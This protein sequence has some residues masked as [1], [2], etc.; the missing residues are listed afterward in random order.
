M[1]VRLWVVVFL[2]FFFAFISQDL[3]N[4]YAIAISMKMSNASVNDASFTQLLDSEKSEWFLILTRHWR[5]AVSGSSTSESQSSRAANPV[6]FH[7]SLVIRLIYT[8][9]VRRMLLTSQ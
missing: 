5:T 1:S 9:D 8:Q 2:F 7:F 3:N 6:A 4:L